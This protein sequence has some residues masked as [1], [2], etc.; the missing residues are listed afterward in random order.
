[1]GDVRVRFLGSGD[2]FGSGGRFQ[3][4]ILVRS[5]HGSTLIDCGA[6]SLIA[7][8][9]FGV[10]PNSVE[11]VLLS[12]LHGDHFGGLPFLI[13]DGQ[14]SRRT[15]PLTIAGPPGVEERV[16]AA[17]EVLFPGSSQTRQRFDLRFVELAVEAE[18]LVG[19]VLV[20]AFPAEHAS[21]AP[22]FA[23]RVECDGRTIAYSGDTAWTEG[24]IRV[25]DDAD[26]LICEAYYFEKRVPFHLDYQTLMRHRASLRCGRIVLTHMSSD[27]L[28]HIGTVSDECA[29]DGLELDLSG[30]R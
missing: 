4:C 23:L 27:M 1:M 22:A 17:M 16:R 15:R 26:L 10:D 24:L 21:G 13:L 29:V 7:M 2:A 9:R 11:A 30:E 8:K 18:T 20:T 28:S 6:S 12:H 3:T 25:A 5:S 14:F 19:S